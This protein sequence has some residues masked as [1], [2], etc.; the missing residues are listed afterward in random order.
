M[1]RSKSY[2]PTKHSFRTK[3]KPKTEIF[4]CP[5]AYLWRSAGIHSINSSS[6]P[7]VVSWFPIGIIHNLLQCPYSNCPIGPSRKVSSVRDEANRIDPMNV[8]PKW[9]KERL[10]SNCIPNECSIV[11]GSWRDSP[12]VQWEVHRSYIALV[13]SNWSTNYFTTLSIPNKD[14]G[15]KGPGDDAWPIKGVCYR[16]YP[17]KND[18]WVLKINVQFLNSN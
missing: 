9:R 10:T 11:S 2:I 6:S 17:Q 8:T 12:S 14:C 1:E 5:Q 13:P 18:Y 7:A 15:T 4:L 16:F 3:M